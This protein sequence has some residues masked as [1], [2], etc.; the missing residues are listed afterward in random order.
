MRQQVQSNNI[1]IQILEEQ[2]NQLRKN[3]SKMLDG[4]GQK[5]QGAKV[6]SRD[7]QHI[8]F[9]TF[10]NILG[11]L[12]V[13]A[14]QGTSVEKGRNGREAIRFSAFVCEQQSKQPLCKSV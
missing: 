11:I 12:Q 13:R 5:H 8:L 2:N 4:Q 7:E 14:M 10:L 9:Y 6:H 3:I 1:R